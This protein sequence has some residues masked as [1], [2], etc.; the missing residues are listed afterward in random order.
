MPR[1]TQPM[2]NRLADLAEEYEVALPGRKEDE[3][4][5]GERGFL[6]NIADYYGMNS[7][8][9]WWRN[10]LKQTERKTLGSRENT[11]RYGLKPGWHKEG[12]LA[13]IELM[14]GKEAYLKARE[15]MEA[16]EKDASGF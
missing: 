11:L 14:E 15:M 2:E 10:L 3:G 8:G 6:G 5:F 1:F 16:R 4:L 9:D 13:V 7:W 12:K